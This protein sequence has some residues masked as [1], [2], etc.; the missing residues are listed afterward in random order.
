[1]RD[2][3][4]DDRYAATSCQVLA[5]G[6]QALARLP[7]EIARLDQ[8]RG[9]NTAGYISGYRGSPLGG[10][11]QELSDASSFLQSANVVFQPGINEELA[12][13]AVWGTQQVNFL[14]GAKYDGVFGIWYGKAPGVDRAIDPMR[15]AN[16]AGTWSNG[17]VVVLAGDDPECKSSTLPNQSEF[18]LIHAEIPVL[19]PSDV[20][21][22]LDFGVIALA[23]SRYS[24]CWIGMIA[25]TDNVDSHAVIDVGIER[26]THLLRPEANKGAPDVH[27]RAQDNAIAQEARMRMVKLPAVLDFA[28]TA[29]LNRIVIR[30]AQPRIGIVATGRAYSETMQ[31]LHDL[32]LDVETAASLGISVLKIGMSWPLDQEAMREFA[33]G[34]DTLLVVEDKRALLES[35]IK[36]ALYHTPSEK[37]PQIIG[38]HDAK[39]QPLLKDSGILTATE[40]TTAIAS[41]LPQNVVPILSLQQKPRVTRGQGVIETRDPFY[42][43]GCPHNRSTKVLSGSH[44]LAGI[45]CHYMARWTSPETTFFSAM[46]GEGVQWLGQAPFTDTPH[47]FANL[48]DGTYFHSGL[49]AIRQ[50]V[51]AKA[52]ITYKILYNDAVAMT[53]G[54]S[55]DG[56]LDVPAITHQLAAEGVCRIAVVAEDVSRYGDVTRLAMGTTVHPRDDLKIVET[57]FRDTEGV[58]AIIYDQMCAAEKRRRRKRGLLTDSP[59]RAFINELVCEGCG[60]CSTK[61]NCISVEPI[62][63][64]LGR[65]RRINQSSCNKDFSCVD[66]FCPSFVTITGAEPHS[67][68]ADVILSDAAA[69]PM[70]TPSPLHTPYNILVSGIGG[71]GVTTIAAILAMAAHIENRSVRTLNRTGLAQKGGAVASH[72]RIALKSTDMP[73]P[74][75]PMGETDVHLAYDMIVAASPNAISRSSSGRTVTLLNTHINPTSA[76]VRDTAKT[77]DVTGLETKLR[78]TSRTLQTIE[79]RMLAETFLGNELYANMIM[80]GYALQKGWLPLTVAALAK[81]IELNGASC[82]QNMKALALGRVAAGAPEKIA[83]YS[84]NSKKMLS[85]KLT[86]S[87]DEII[88]TRVQYLTAYQNAAYAHQY[89]SLIAH[90]RTIGY[91][92]LVEALAR[93]AFAAMMIKDEYEVARLLTDQAFTDQINATFEG[94]IAV[95]YHLAPA[96]LARKSK[97]TGESGKMTFG[98]WLKPVL[99]I[100][101]KMKR[102]RETPLDPLKFDPLRRAERHFRDEYLKEMS[103]ILDRVN[104]SNIQI[105]IDIAVLPLDA[106][107]YGHIKEASLIKMKERFAALVTAFKTTPATAIPE[108]VRRAS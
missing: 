95:S 33:R 18:G 60:D 49:L 10:Y 81:A 38:K 6:L 64:E 40:I 72:V 37:R 74:A 96:F 56:K 85:P 13:T 53:G 5:T 98:P 30:A 48:G 84:D 12:A 65:K 77:Y 22:M 55:V 52:R 58:T 59:K 107:G 45:G 24:G 102:L 39:D 47:I 79:A 67:F 101:A 50:A 93:G 103:E 82:K 99:K 32:K 36:E 80:L 31:A 28:R 26:Y 4:L 61:S 3:T 108:P 41:I 71:L 16:F 14:P 35:Q 43:S 106:R 23:M 51:A 94:N 73:T 7:L 44:A 88:S 83:Q 1:M 68:K 66:G 63:T 89:E 11:D 54:Q 69:L 104:P 87:V 21:D 92:K 19:N 75:V 57:T 97:A 91:K 27:I 76:F 78:N 9:L 20:Q 2:V 86:A 100:V 8:A 46:G 25:T 90:A 17:G 15:H 105:A 29:G 34:L 42:C 62:E 70:P